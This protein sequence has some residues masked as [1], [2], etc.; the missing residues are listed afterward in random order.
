MSFPIP[1][2]PKSYMEEAIEFGIA[3]EGAGL[4]LDPGLGKTGITLAIICV[5]LEMKLI[6]RVL[7]CAPK[8]VA[9]VTWADEVKKWVDFNHLKIDTLCELDDAG[10]TAKLKGPAQILTI[11]PE[12]AHKV[13]EHPLFDTFMLDMLVLDE[14]TKWKDTQTKRFKSLKKVIRSFIRR[15]ILTGTPVPNGLQDLFGQMYVVDF[16][17]SLGKFITHFRMMYMYQRP[18]DI[19]SYHLRPGA[20]K[21]IY[22]AVRGNLMRMRAVD[23]LDMPE[24]IQDVRWVDLP[25]SCKQQYKEL[26]DEFITKVDDKTV[27]GLTPAAVGTKCRQFA[28]GFLYHEPEG[29]GPRETIHIHDA[30]LDAL[31]ELVDEMLGRPLLVGYEFIADAERIQARFPD[32]VNLGTSKNPAQIIERF[33]QGLIPILLG[34]PASVGHGLNLQ[35]MC[36]DVCWYSD[37]WDLELY[38]Q[39]IAR[40]WRQGQPSSFVTIHHISCRG[41]RDEKVAKVL[42]DKD[43]TQEKFN[44]AL[45]SP[46]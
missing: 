5:L 27:V 32:A 37:P 29:G 25:A 13:F 3:H 10:R 9:M 6:R 44:E 43:A 28:N 14:S 21:Q 24:I 17:A 40:V 35:A 45:C 11:N 30:K 38:Q 4:M 1:Y 12:S 16:G 8:R 23:H 31:A 46:L 19:Y 22:G 41:T 42:A 7:V 33:N 2:V 36:H 15:L 18:G 39:F 26:D 20:D 34:H